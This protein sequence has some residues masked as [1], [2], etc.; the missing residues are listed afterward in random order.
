M[1]PK[2]KVRLLD[3]L[4]GSIQQKNKIF[5]DA[6]FSGIKNEIELGTITEESKV[7]DL[8]QINK[9]RELKNEMF[10]SSTPELKVI[11]NINSDKPVS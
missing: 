7:K 2:K 6:L 11:K 1:R 10:L 9:T 3:I 5:T 4:P 8:A